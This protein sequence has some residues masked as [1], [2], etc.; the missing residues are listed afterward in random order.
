[1]RRRVRVCFDVQPIRK[2]GCEGSNGHWSHADPGF[3]GS[4]TT[5]TEAPRQNRKTLPKVQ[6]FCSR[7]QCGVHTLQLLLGRPAHIL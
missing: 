2:E 3:H 4:R 5:R 7:E 6:H 1:M